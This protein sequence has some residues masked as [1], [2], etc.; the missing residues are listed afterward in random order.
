MTPLRNSL[1][2]HLEKSSK[3]V[4]RQSRNSLI[5]NRK[6]IEVANKIYE[7]WQLKQPTTAEIIKIAEDPATTFFVRLKLLFFLRRQHPWRQWTRLMQYILHSLQLS[8]CHDSSLLQQL[9]NLTDFQ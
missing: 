7:S 8:I 5:T 2:E 3:E 1:L 4:G 6:N 9:Q